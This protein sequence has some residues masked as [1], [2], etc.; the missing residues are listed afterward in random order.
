MNYDPATELKLIYD[1]LS[2]KRDRLLEELDET[3]KLLEEYQKAIVIL[4]EN[5]GGNE[6]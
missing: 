4:L 3:S 6:E 5:T 1:S 2:K